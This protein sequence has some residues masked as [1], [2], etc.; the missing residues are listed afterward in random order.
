M[1]G[2]QNLAAVGPEIWREDENGL[3]VLGNPDIRRLEIGLV[4]YSDSTDRNVDRKRRAHVDPLFFLLRSVV[5]HA[6]QGPIEQSVRCRS[7]T[8][9]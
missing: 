6:L 7:N 5:S 2:C 1:P 3:Q 4:H 8:P 9:I